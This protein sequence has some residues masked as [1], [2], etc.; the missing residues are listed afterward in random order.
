[1]PKLL[2]SPSMTDVPIPCDDFAMYRNAE[3]YH[4]GQCDL[5]SLTS[6]KLKKR[7]DIFKWSAEVP[8]WRCTVYA[9]LCEVKDV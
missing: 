2:S 8:E 5:Y 7:M 6:T 1:M 9:M 4:V 3:A